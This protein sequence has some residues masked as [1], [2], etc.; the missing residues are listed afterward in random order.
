MAGAALMREE[1]LDDPEQP[2]DTR[3][4]PKLFAHLAADRLLGGLQHLDTSAGQ[5]PEIF[6]IGLLGENITVVKA[7][8]HRAIAEAHGSEIEG[9]HLAAGSSCSISRSR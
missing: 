5:R 8:S 2:L 4:E 9:D 6:V 3:L 1:I 7:N